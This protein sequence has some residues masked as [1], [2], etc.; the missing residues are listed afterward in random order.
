MAIGEQ[1]VTTNDQSRVIEFLS[2]PGT[3]CQGAAEKIETHISLI[4]LGPERVF[5]L[6]R[7]VVFPYLDFSTADK[8]RAA[9]EAEV[10][11][12]RRTAPDL[13]RGVAAVTRQADGG[14]AIDGTGEA[15]DWL[16]EMNRFDQDGLLDRMALRGELNR[17]LMGEIAQCIAAFH[18]AAEPVRDF[19]GREGMQ[20]IITGN[21]EVFAEYGPG[22]VAGDKLARLFD[23]TQ[24]ALD[25]VSALLDARRGEGF[26]RRCHGDLHLRNVV[27]IGGRP[28]LFDAIEFNDAIS[29]IDVL[30]DLAFLL[31][32]LDHRGLRRLANITFNSYLDATGDVAGLPALSLFLSVRAAIRAHVAAVMVGTVEEKSAA[33]GLGAEARA[34]L[35]MA[36]DYLAPPPSRLVAVG[37][38][39]GSG[40]SRLAR[41]LAPYLGAAPGAR[42]AR[43]DVLRKRL[44]GFGPRERLGPDGYTAE[45]TEKTYRAVFEEVTPVLASGHSAIADA[46]FA[47]PAMRAAVERLA[48]NAGVP[49]CGLWLEAPQE[50]MIERVESRKN[51]AS[52]ADAKVLRRQLAYDPGTM[53]WSRIDSSGSRKETL[54][55][56]LRALGLVR[57]NF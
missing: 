1:T 23:A 54:A 30:Y 55:N 45:M 31:M 16:V 41:E 57:G 34:Y 28:V 17:R 53:D 38:L 20:A 50:V 21:R 12:N 35:D 56:G 11:I 36:L 15:V 44:L 42:V 52:D 7:A 26:V 37:G 19:G 4:F 27:M 49:F 40:K 8:R 51:N 2:R 10:S 48:G 47:K 33:D 43:S 29:H 9:C 18:A 39:S 3:I 46:V 6:K 22:V 13:Y 25:K 5:K 32:D 24:A 14:L